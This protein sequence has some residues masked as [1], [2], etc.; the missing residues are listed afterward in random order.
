MKLG[1]NLNYK[2]DDN[3]G[4]H[5]LHTLWKEPND[6]LWTN[7]LVYLNHSLYDDLKINLYGILKK[8]LERKVKQENET[9]K[10]QTV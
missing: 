4:G 9:I 2:F 6:D 7:L 10:H 1:K 5:L 3:L 8:N